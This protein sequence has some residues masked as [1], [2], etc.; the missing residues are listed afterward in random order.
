MSCYVTHMLR[1]V[2]KKS[3]AT[4][5]Y[6]QLR[7]HIV[8]GEVRPGDALPSERVLS[9]TLKVNRGAVREGLKRLE[10]AGL[11]AVQQG[12]ATQVL[13]FRSTA[14]LEI[15][16]ALVVRNGRVDTRVARSILEL[17]AA[18]GPEVARACARRRAAGELP[19]LVER[20]RK[21]AGDLALLSDLALDF[22]GEVV[23]GSDGLAWQLAYN[24]MRASYGL[25][26]GHL[27]H[28][29]AAELKAV[30]DYAAL[31]K[32]IERGD[33][34]AAARSASTIVAR[35]SRELAKVLEAIDREEGGNP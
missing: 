28:V 20:M 30:K 24:S 11:V 10:Q 23:R 12:G 4:S 25:V 22:W 35:G 27:T 14:G 19:A 9:E 32:A 2:A 3:L 1:P 8:S 31:A 17:R 16:G 6:E 15:L 7:D 13:D 21:A 18:L 26:Q 33:E 34:A 29:L 5:V